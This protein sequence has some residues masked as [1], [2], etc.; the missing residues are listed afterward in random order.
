MAPGISLT[1]KVSLKNFGTSGGNLAPQEGRGMTLKPLGDWGK[2]AYPG[3]ENTPR[4]ARTGSPRRRRVGGASSALFFRGIAIGN[5]IP[6]LPLFISLL[7]SAM[8]SFLRRAT[9][10][11]QV[12]TIILTMGTLL[13]YMV[14]V[15]NI[16][17]YAE[18]LN[19]TTAESIT[20]MKQILPF[21]WIT[22]AIYSGDLI[23]VLLTL[24]ITVIPLILAVYI[25]TRG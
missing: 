3:G 23:C 21:Y 16:S 18:E 24:L 5:L 15:P 19:I 11:G 10:F 6:A 2:P 1:S 22:E 4:P 9:K 14:V 25:H 20:K 13:L 12:A 7:I 17:S 8:I